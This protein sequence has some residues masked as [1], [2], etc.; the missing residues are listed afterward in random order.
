MQFL[1]LRARFPA[2]AVVISHLWSAPFCIRTMA[3]SRQVIN[4]TLAGASKIQHKLFFF[5]SSL[6]IWKLQKNIILRGVQILSQPVLTGNSIVRYWARR[7]QHGIF[8]GSVPLLLLPICESNN[9]RYTG[10]PADFL[11]RFQ[12]FDSGIYSIIISD[13]RFIDY[14][15]V[16]GAKSGVV[17]S[18]GKSQ[19]QS[20]S[21][22]IS[23]ET[24]QSRKCHWESLHSLVVHLVPGSMSCVCTGN[25]HSPRWS[26]FT[27][28]RDSLRNDRWGTNRCWHRY[29]NVG[30][31]FNFHQLY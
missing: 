14:F 2:A 20:I 31:S 5:F 28:W 21:S 30:I 1:P 12:G 11:F 4:F 24:S 25:C 10:L 15:N 19:L 8:I 29:S 6:I 13:S 7:L 22:T 16:K 18:M 9:L 17:A 26:G 3:C 27:S 23:K